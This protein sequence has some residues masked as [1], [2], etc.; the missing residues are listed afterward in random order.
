MM[1]D[2]K[3]QALSIVIQVWIKPQ[4]AIYKQLQYSPLSRMYYFKH[5][6]Y[7]YKKMSQ[8]FQLI[9]YLNELLPDSQ[10][11]QKVYKKLSNYISFLAKELT[12][13]NVPYGS[14]K[15]CGKHVTCFDRIANSLRVFC[16]S[17]DCRTTSHVLLNVFYE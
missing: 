6:A 7:E 17:E 3:L 11:L 1:S 10:L 4:N 15:S 5:Q 9:S 2:Y 13:Y 14:C 8:Y 16:S 12:L